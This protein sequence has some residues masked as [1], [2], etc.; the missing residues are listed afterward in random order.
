MSEAETWLT[1]EVKNRLFSKAEIKLQAGVRKLAPVLFLK[2]LTLLK[3]KQV[4]NIH[5]THIIKRLI[6]NCQNRLLYTV[7]NAKMKSIITARIINLSL[8]GTC[9]KCYYSK[10]VVMVFVGGW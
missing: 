2:G 4:K 10:G 7:L 6:S 3:T 9:C 1:S 8:S 5:H